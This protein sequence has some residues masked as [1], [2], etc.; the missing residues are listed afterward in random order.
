MKRWIPKSWIPK[1]AREQEQYFLTVSE[2]LGNTTATLS[3][4]EQK[5]NLPFL[6]MLQAQQRQINALQRDGRNDRQRV[7]QAESENRRLRG[8]VARLE[9]RINDIERSL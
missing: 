7:E 5:S 6:G 4:E 9:A 1:S 3:D 2:K 8:I